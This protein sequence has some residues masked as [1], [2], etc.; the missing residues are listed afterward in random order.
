MIL[1]GRFKDKKCTRIPGFIIFLI[2][3]ILPQE[4]PCMVI[5]EKEGVQT[6][7]FDE[8]VAV[9]PSSMSLAVKVLRS[10]QH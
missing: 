6:Q 9:Y 2:K 8:E 7:D 10:P 3:Y 1:L 5:N 4:L